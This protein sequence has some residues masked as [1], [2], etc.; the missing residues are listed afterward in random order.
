MS[1]EIFRQLQTIGVMFFHIVRRQRKQ[2]RVAARMYS[3]W[4]CV[5]IYLPALLAVPV[6][7]NDIRSDS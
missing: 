6:L 3:T 7:P 4:V 5:A 1:V 2:P